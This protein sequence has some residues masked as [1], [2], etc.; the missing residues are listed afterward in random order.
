MPGLGRRADPS[1]DVHGHPGDVRSRRARA[2]RCGRRQRRAIPASAASRQ[3]VSAQRTA[4]LGPSN[5]LNV[6]SPMTLTSSPPPFS[7]A[8]RTSRSWADRMSRYFA[9]PTLDRSSVEE[10]TSVNNTVPRNR[11]SSAEWIVPGRHLLDVVGDRQD[12]PG[13]WTRRAGSRE[14]SGKSLRGG[15]PPRGATAASGMVLDGRSQH[16]G[17]HL[18]RSQHVLDVDLEDPVVVGL[19]A[20]GVADD[21]SRSAINRRLKAVACTG[22]HMSMTS[23]DPQ[24]VN[25]CSVAVHGT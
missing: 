23:P 8:S 9:S 5:T 14:G 22:S 24:F 13:R 19:A 21:R 17:R 1:A 20:A 15:A 10:T 18:H 12:T 3:I 7:T 16:P 4:L 6:P 25:A 2:R 11:S